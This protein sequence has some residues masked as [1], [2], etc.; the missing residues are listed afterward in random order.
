MQNQ[1][2]LKKRV[3]VRSHNKP[4]RHKMTAMCAHISVVILQMHKLMTMCAHMADVSGVCDG[5]LYTTNGVN[6]KKIY[7]RNGARHIMQLVPLNRPSTH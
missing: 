6:L 4:Q 1:Q 7:S 2:M 3:S 5:N